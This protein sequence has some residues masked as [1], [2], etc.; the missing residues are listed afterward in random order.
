MAT[1][2][3]TDAELAHGLRR[4]RREMTAREGRNAKTDSSPRYGGLPSRDRLKAAKDSL[5]LARKL[6]DFPNNTCPASRH[7]EMI[8]EYLIK[9][10]PYAMLEEE[11]EHCGGSILAVVAALYEARTELRKLKK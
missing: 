8:G 2:S 1:D 7:A 4:L 5:K 3:M 11:P 10:K 9:G 6:R